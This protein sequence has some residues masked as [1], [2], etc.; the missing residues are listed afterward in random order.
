MIR[1]QTLQSRYL[2]ILIVLVISIMAGCAAKKTLWG[3]TEKGLILTYRME[4]DDVFQYKTSADQIQSFEVMGQT[5]ENENLVTMMF[6]VKPK[7]SSDQNLLLDVTIDSME[8]NLSSPQGEYSPDLSS[9]FGK[10]F[11][12]H[13]THLG[14]EIDVSG[15]D[16]IQYSLPNGKRSLQS[17]FNAIFPDLAEKTVKIG[18]TWNSKDDIVSKEGNIEVHIVIDNLNTLAGLETM[19][20]LECVKITTVINGTLAGE[21][22]QMGNDMA[23]E[24]DVKGKATWYFAYKKGLFV[25]MSTEAVSEIDIE[26][27]G[28]N[29][30]IP[31]IDES[32]S[33]IELV[34]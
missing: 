10:S 24:G 12:M 28:Q 14:K 32:R 13:L 6:S 1:I 2:F 27:I 29:M 7:E 5:M 26:V 30:N 21:G 34:K 33:E 20:G 17:S 16:S 9:I 19:K 23:F 31:M 22:E 11:A 18:D 15:A 25:K 8:M 4:G 3:D